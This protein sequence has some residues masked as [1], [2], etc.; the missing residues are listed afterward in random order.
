MKCKFCN[1]TI[2][3]YD[4]LKIFHQCN[5]PSLTH[6]SDGI[7]KLFYFWNLDG[8]FVTVSNNEIIV[9]VY[10]DGESENQ[11]LFR[12]EDTYDLHPENV[13]PFLKKILSLK[14]FL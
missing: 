9:S 10:R 6:I 7:S 11:I 14:A 2:K 1:S 5:C 4:T 12:D 8:K 13:A 3:P